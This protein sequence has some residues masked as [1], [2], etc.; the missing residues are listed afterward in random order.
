MT[1]SSM[2]AGDSQPVQITVTDSGTGA[3]A[4]L[5]GCALTWMLAVAPGGTA[6]VTKT[7]AGG[8]IAVSGAGSNI[9]TVSLEPA[10]TDALEPG[11][12]YHE[13]KVVD[14]AAQVHTAVQDKLQILAWMIDPTP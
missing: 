13:L 11:V 12:Y 2:Y 6:L 9:V 14:L 4:D 7:S 1:L 3:A 10:D 5:T 8:D